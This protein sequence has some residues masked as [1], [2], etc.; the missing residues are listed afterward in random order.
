MAGPGRRR[1]GGLLLVVLLLLAITLGC[2]QTPTAQAPTTASSASTSKEVTMPDGLKYTDD[3]VGTGAEAATGKTVSVHY[4]GWLLDGTKFDSSRDRNQPFS[5]PL[6]RGQVIKGWDE[7]V[8]G[9]KVGGKRTLV[10][11]P[12]LGYGARGAGGVIPPNATLKF[13]VELLDVK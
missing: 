2:S 5:F 7:G 11:P 6:G 8:A 12:D 10:I 3:Q 4:T 1:R 9:M 13:E